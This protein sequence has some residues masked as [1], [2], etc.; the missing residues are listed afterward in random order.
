M[1]VMG[2]SLTL[3][4]NGPTSRNVA[5]YMYLVIGVICNL[6]IWDCCR[7]LSLD[8]GCAALSGGGTTHM[9]FGRALQ[10]GC[11]APPPHRIGG[12]GRG[13]APLMHDTHSTTKM[14]SKTHP[15]H[16]TTH[17]LISNAHFVTHKAP[18]KSLDSITIAT[19]VK[20]GTKTK[21]RRSPLF[22]ALL[23]SH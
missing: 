17:F 18:C 12:S 3:L 14:R 8:P 19:E 2:A 9:P 4:F 22:A 11:G 7:L 21:Q 16:S 20:Q 10:G 1:V 5:G 13:S 23:E 15:T 6:F